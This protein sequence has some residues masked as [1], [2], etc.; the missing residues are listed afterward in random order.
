MRHPNVPESLEG[1]WILHRM[2]AFD[3]LAWDALPESE[4]T[5]IV[6]EATAALTPFQQSK[7]SDVGLAQILGHKADLMLT[8]Y[9]R[10][11]DGLAHAQIVFDK[12]RLSEYLTPA[13]SYVS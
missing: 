4:R 8:H 6:Q 12:T 10:N 3:R 13:T 5:K 11:Y 2:F 1:W 7:D 9:S